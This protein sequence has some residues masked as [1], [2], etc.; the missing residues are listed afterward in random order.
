MAECFELLLSLEDV[1]VG[2]W[3][4]HVFRELDERPILIVEVRKA[5]NGMKTRKSS[6]LDEFPLE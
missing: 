5:V 3:K 2:D 1:R 4:M 6:G